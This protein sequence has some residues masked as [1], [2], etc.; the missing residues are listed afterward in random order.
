MA[1][2]PE[3]VVGFLRDL[4]KKSRPYALKDMEELREFAAKELGIESLQP[5]ISA[6]LRKN[7][8]RRATPSLTRK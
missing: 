8:V 2:T 4:N 5:G 1:E 6:S 7:S 3:Q